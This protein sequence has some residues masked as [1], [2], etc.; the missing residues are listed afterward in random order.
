MR[1]QA[2]GF[3]FVAVL[4]AALQTLAA[5]GDQKR[6]RPPQWPKTVKDVFFDDARTKLSGPRPVAGDKATVAG[7]PSGDGGDAA[8]TS[9]SGTFTWSKLIDPE[10]L[11][12][13]TKTIQ[14]A[15]SENVT[16]PAKFKG[17]GYKE[18]RL[19]LSMQAVVFAI[20]AEYDGEVRWQK[21]PPACAT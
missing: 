17:G 6:A 4:L 13:E 2:S 18:G 19:L 15:L 20:I 5:V 12:S 1:R 8:N 7:T 21:R 10:T 16:T 11:E 9:Q 14:A 3:V